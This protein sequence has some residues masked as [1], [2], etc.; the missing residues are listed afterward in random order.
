MGNKKMNISE[1]GYKLLPWAVVGGIL[2]YVGGVT[3]V[4]SLAG[5]GAGSGAGD[6]ELATTIDIGGSCYDGS[7]LVY[8]AT[9][10]DYANDQESRVNTSIYVYRDGDS[11]YSLASTTSSSGDVTS[12]D[13][14]DCGEEFRAIMGDDDGSGTDYYFAETTGTADGEKSPVALMLK[15]EGT[16]S[17]T[18]SNETS[19]G[20]SSVYADFTASQENTDVTFKVKNSNQNSYWGDTKYLVGV[21]GAS[22][23][24]SDFDIAS[25]DGYDVE[26]ITCPQSVS[27]Y[28]TG[29]VGIT[30]PVMKC[31]EVTPSGDSKTNTKGVFTD[32]FQLYATPLNLVPDQNLTIFTAD[33]AGRIKNGEIVNG[34]EN[35]DTNAD[36]GA[37][38]VYAI[39]A[40]VPY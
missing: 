6:S 31:F 34:Y 28:I 40:V 20:A 33:Y 25:L 1:I 11:V 36:M 39:A 7:D 13:F 17:L 10:M 30:S 16:V 27:T 37:S 21:A 9:L 4:L 23:N 38:N 15:P 35:T 12:A 19:F 2:V 18:F 3:G 24:Y 5:D 14:L 32:E 8:G 22:G 26:S 29:T